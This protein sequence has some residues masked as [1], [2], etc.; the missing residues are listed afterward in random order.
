MV[1]IATLQQRIQL[2]AILNIPPKLLPL[3]IEIDGY[4]YFLV[5]GGRG[6][7]KSQTVARALLVLGEMENLRIVCGREVQN[8]I[9]ESVYQI[10][11]DLIKEH[12][13]NYRIYS[14]RIVH[15]TTGTTFTFKGFREHGKVNI[16]G[17]E[18]V[19]I[20]WID[21]SQTITS[22]TL[23][24]LIPTIRA[25]NAKVFFTMNRYVADDPVFKEFSTFNRE[26]TWGAARTDCIHIH[27]DYFENPHCPENQLK[28]AAICKARNMEDYKHI[29]LGIPMKQAESAAFRN[30]EAIIDDELPYEIPPDP[31]FHY[32]LGVDFGKSVD[33]TV[34][35][36]ICIEL[37]CQVYFERLESENKANW[38]YQKKKTLAISKKYNNALIVPDSTGVGDPIVED[39]E[40]MGGNV[41]YEESESGKNTSGVKFTGVSKENLI[42]KLKI[43][44]EMGSIQIPRITN[45]ENKTIQVTELVKF[46][47][48]KMSSGKFRYAAPIGK[49]PEGNDLYHDDC[50]ISLA[51]AVWGARDFLYLKDFEEPQELTETDI[52]WAKVKKDLARNKNK[53]LTDIQIESNLEDDSTFRILDTD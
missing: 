52:F 28:E 31:R 23:K 15:R 8:T 21:E 46:E 5:E 26:K 51:L 16:K 1:D 33:H 32:V 29:W 37:K 34:L 44:I 40:K 42:S 41:Y 48:V 7:A 9:K 43:V 38:F 2:P 18:G 12:D 49:D 24:I 50:V 10:L 27:I 14:E 47:A 36:V 22:P 20:L 45:E 39:L 4:K 25:E 3:I 11:V 13:L 30:V 6:S 35:T 17:L 53:N 19:D